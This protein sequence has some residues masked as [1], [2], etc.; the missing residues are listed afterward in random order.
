[1]I[2]RLHHPLADSPP[3]PAKSD[4]LSCGLPFRLQLLSAPHFTMAQLLSATT[5]WHTPTGIFT[6]LMSRPRGRTSD[7]LR[8][9]HQ[10]PGKWRAAGG[11]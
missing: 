2:F 7:K 3:Y 10:R 6:L 11:S 4:S 8:L 1:M 9:S 5:L